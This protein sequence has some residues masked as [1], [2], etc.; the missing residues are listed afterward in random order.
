MYRRRNS[1]VRGCRQNKE[2]IP[3]GI[4]S[5]LDLRIF[6]YSSTGTAGNSSG[7]PCSVVLRGSLG[8]GGC[9]PSYCM[10]SL[11]KGESGSPKCR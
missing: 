6:A 8:S 7:P 5:F 2:P 10:K 11:F 4:G 1:D 9:C 3:E